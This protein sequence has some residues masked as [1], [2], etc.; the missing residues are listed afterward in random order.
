MPEGKKYVFKSALQSSSVNSC[1]PPGEFRAEFYLNGQPLDLG[2]NGRISF[3]QGSSRTDSQYK[4]AILRD[5]DLEMC[6]PSDWVPWTFKDNPDP[7]LM[8]GY[9]APDRSSAA[10][11][12]TYYYPKPDAQTSA[13]VRSGLVE[14]SLKS[15][16]SEGLISQSNMSP[17]PLSCTGYLEDSSVSRARYRSAE[18]SVLAK[19]WFANDGIAHVGLVFRRN[20]G[21]RASQESAVT[22]IP[23]RQSCDVFA[24]IRV[25]YASWLFPNAR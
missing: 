18:G 4:S 7:G 2:A 9:S 12:F 10:F 3:G 24:S 15:L 17:E 13:S 11:L 5:L 14:K 6:Y 21:A 20:S 22:G 1:I 25:Y 19:V 23:D 16:A 8:A